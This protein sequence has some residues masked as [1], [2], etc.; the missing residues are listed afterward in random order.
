MDQWQKE[1]SQ[2]CDLFKESLRNCP[3]AEASMEIGVYKADTSKEFCEITKTLPTIGYSVISIDP[4]G[5]AP[6][7]V[8][9]TLQRCDFNEVAYLAAKKALVDYE[10]SILFRM[11]SRD[12]LLSLN[13]LFL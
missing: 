1:R 4:W 2:L 12:F 6:Y 8:G 7:R 11:S 13:F 5:L 3:G 10:H 9:Y